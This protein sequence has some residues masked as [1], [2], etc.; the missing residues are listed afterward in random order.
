MTIERRRAP[1]YRLVAAA[2]IVELRSNAILSAKTSDVSL[3]GCFMNTARAFPEGTRIRLKLTIDDSSFTSLGVVARLQP[4]G[5]GVSFSEMKEDQSNVLRAWFL[6]S[7][8][9]REC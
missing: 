6:E 4:M 8:R 9:G 1:R 2:E 3:V 7:G 5:M